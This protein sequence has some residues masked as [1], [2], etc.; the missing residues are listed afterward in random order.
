VTSIFIL[1]KLQGQNFFDSLLIALT[2]IDIIFIIF[3]IV[4]YTL[5]REFSW[6]WPEDS[7]VWVYLIPKFTYPLNN[8]CFCASVF[9]TVLIAGE[10]YLAVCHPILYRNMAV[11]TSVRQR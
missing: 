6:P 10:R 11:S 3:T 2:T 4:D 7:M 8:M 9:L 1:T 5:A